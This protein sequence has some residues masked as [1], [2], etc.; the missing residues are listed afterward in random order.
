MG[1][2]RLGLRYPRES[3]YFFGLALGIFLY[4]WIHVL[5]K[6]PFWDTVLIVVIYY[7]IYGYLVYLFAFRKKKEKF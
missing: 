4:V 1:L 7:M 5:L 3:V 6:H 2:G